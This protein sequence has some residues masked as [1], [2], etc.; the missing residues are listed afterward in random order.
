M[1]K[2]RY[3]G[4]TIW[5]TGGETPLGMQMAKMF[6][7][8]GANLLISGVTEFSS[9]NEFPNNNV[10]CYEN[11]PIN[12]KYTNEALSLIDNLDVTI[13][14]NRYI[15]RSSLMDATVELFDDVIEKNL[16]HAWCAARGTAGKIGK[17]TLLT[18]GDTVQGSTVGW[19]FSMHT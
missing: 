2:K 4:K 19:F 18:H 11:N 5:I 14:T 12:E 1:N 8:E 17:K 3:S 9:I 15:I 13:I 6:L 7:A 10:I 16:T